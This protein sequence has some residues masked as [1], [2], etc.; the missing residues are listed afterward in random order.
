MGDVEANPGRLILSGEK[1]YD[2][3]TILENPTMNLIATE[4]KTM[5]YWRQLRNHALKYF[6]LQDGISTATPLVLRKRYT[7]PQSQRASYC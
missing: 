7:V 2:Y 5:K 6:E 3:I 4:N 1:R